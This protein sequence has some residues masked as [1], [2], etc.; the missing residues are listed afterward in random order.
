MP[1]SLLG[2]WSSRHYCLSSGLRSQMI[3]R[4]K[5]NITFRQVV[6]PSLQEEST[7]VRAIDQVQHN[8]EAG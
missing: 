8:G 4:E 6:V 3:Y 5:V 7:S 2:L 1:P